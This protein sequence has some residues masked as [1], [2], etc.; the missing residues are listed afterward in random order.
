MLP[1]GGVAVEKS[2]PTFLREQLSCTR[3]S[4]E[5]RRRER[6]RT[7]P[8]LASARLTG[9]TRPHCSSR[10]LTSYSAATASV[11]SYKRAP[12]LFASTPSRALL[13][14]S[15]RSQLVSNRHGI[16]SS[17]RDC[18]RFRRGGS[19][20]YFG[21]R[22]T[23]TSS[24]PVAIQGQRARWLTLSRSSGRTDR[25]WSAWERRGEDN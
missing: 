22:P 4:C 6:T 15:R 9:W 10:F 19:G 25:R 8:T 7:E 5:A 1:S 18:S 13:T 17:L 20:R 14:Q 11:I 24:N 3:P 2:W 12:A 21:S 16:A 23:P